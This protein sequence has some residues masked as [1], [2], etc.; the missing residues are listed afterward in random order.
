MS[1]MSP[2]SEVPESAPLSIGDLVAQTAPGVLSVWGGDISGRAFC[3]ALPDATHYAA[4]T[5]K[6]PLLVAAYRLHERGALDLDRTV[7]VH[8]R[9]ASALDGSAF[10]LDRDDDQD[11][12]TWDRLGGETTLRAL[13]RHAIVR[14]GNL[15]TNLVLE[16]VGT[17]EVAAVLRDAGCTAA[18][19]LPRGIE[20]AAARE[21]G[22]D[23]LV[24]ARDLGLVMC[25]VAA[26]TLASPDTCREVEA[27]LAAQEHRDKIPAGLPSSTYVANKTGWV[28]GV[29]HDVALVRPD[30]ADPY[31]LAVCTTA[32]LSDDEAS[33][34]IAAVSTRIWQERV[35]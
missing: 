10:S 32:S 31:V 3:S 22:L 27:V 34:V 29:A 11:D 4:S 25:G 18:T 9:F 20:D 7:P 16:H 15:A 8:N 13:V 2:T 35:G 14:S 24:T 21:A 19:T 12:E 6:L 23:N 5:M 17:A 26:R 28:T 1:P 33:R 30:D